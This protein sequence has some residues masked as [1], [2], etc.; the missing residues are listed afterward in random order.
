MDEQVPIKAT[1]KVVA[2]K[3][4]G[5]AKAVGKEKAIQKIG[6]GESVKA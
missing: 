3:T 4:I 2:K 5:K 1:K 6:G